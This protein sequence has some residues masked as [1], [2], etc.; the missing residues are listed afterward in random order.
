MGGNQLQEKRIQNLGP[1]VVEDAGKTYM[2]VCQWNHA[3]NPAALQNRHISAI[4]PQKSSQGLP[5][6]SCP[7]APPVLQSSARLLSRQDLLGIKS[8]NTSGINAQ[9]YSELHVLDTDQTQYCYQLY[10]VSQ[11]WSPVCHAPHL[12]DWGY[13]CATPLTDLNIGALTGTVARTLSYLFEVVRWR[14]QVDYHNYHYIRW[15]KS[16]QTKISRKDGNRRSIWDS[17][18]TV[19]VVKS[20]SVLLWR[21]GGVAE[22]LV[23][24][25]A[26][27]NVQGDS[28]LLRIFNFPDNAQAGAVRFLL[29]HGTWVNTA[30]KDLW[31]PMHMAAEMGLPE[32]AQPR[33]YSSTGWTPIFG[34]IMACPIAPSASQGDE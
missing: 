14:M 2:R 20:V 21:A 8:W 25:G 26:C 27:V 34:T 16:K 4:S 11:P 24:Y 15:T 19:Q 22:L 3:K 31:T 18:L 23:K 6:S 7:T 12:P 17:L 9:I 32:I 30:H 13:P 10:H 33:C 1:W 28:A 29:E 5:T